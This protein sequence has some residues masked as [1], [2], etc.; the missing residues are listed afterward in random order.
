MRRP[1]HPRCC[2]W[3]ERRGRPQASSKEARRGERAP[4]LRMRSV[5][6]ARPD[7]RPRCARK[8]AAQ[9]GEN[10]KL[11]IEPHPANARRGRP[12]NSAFRWRRNAGFPAPRPASTIAR[13]APKARK[14]RRACGRRGTLSL[15]LQTE[16]WGTVRDLSRASL[17]TGAQGRLPAERSLH[18]GSFSSTLIARFDRRNEERIA[19]GRGDLQ[20]TTLLKN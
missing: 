14:Q 16:W 13:T 17:E 19:A 1:D 9:E 6:A 10:G 12:R 15:L 2:L 8:R 5:P 18:P 3:A 11:P 20:C 7:F 4:G